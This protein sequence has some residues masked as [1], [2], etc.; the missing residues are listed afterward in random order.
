M[1]ENIVKFEAFRASGGE[2]D[3]FGKVA[4]FSAALRDN[5]ECAPDG[6]GLCCEGGAAK[7][8]RLR[9]HGDAAHHVWML[10]SNSYLGLTRHPRVVEAAEAALRAYGYGTGAV[11]LYTGITLLHRELEQRIARFYGAEDAI[12]FPSGYGTNVGVISALCGPGDVIINDSANHASIFDGATLSGAE[13]KVYPHTSLRGLERVLRALPDAQR[14]RLIVTDG[15]FSMHGDL[16]PLDAI[17]ALARQYNARVMVDDAHGIGI[18]GPTGRGTAEVFGVMAKVDIHVAMLSKAPGG[19]G[20][21]A[22]GSAE[23]IRYLRFYARSYFFSTALPASVCG[24]LIEVFKLLDAD[25]AGRAQLMDAVARFKARLSVAGFTIGESASAIVP[26]II[27]D[28]PKLFRFQHELLDE[29]VYANTVTYPAVR[30]K[31]C[32]LRF[33][34]MLGLTDDDLADI[35]TRMVRAAKRTGVL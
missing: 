27:G 1:D 20:G 15:V 13:L 35:E 33:C 11:S 5:P 19:L 17:T 24:G 10:G 2:S 8:M 3:I 31:E 29:G 9:G 7:R 14:G 21:F 23:L 6:L 4:A 26:V 28:E 22:A 16:A 12:L 32:R 30:R 25:Q 34:M 18:V